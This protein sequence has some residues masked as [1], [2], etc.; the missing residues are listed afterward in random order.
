MVVET[1]LGEQLGITAP[2]TT[3]EVARRLEQ[4]HLPTRWDGLHDT[5]PILRA[6]A[7]DKKA[8]EGSLAFSLLTEIGECKLIAGISA[9]IVRQSLL[10]S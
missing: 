4:F 7:R 10:T 2:G 8:T 1:H 3:K 6:M 5:E 9:D